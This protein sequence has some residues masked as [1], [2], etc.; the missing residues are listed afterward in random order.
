MTTYL[1]QVLG[2]P[3]WDAKGN[4]LGQCVDVLVAEAETGFPSMRALA[5]R[6]GKEPKLISAEC[7]AWL[8]PSI[9]LGTC[10]PPL[11]QVKGDELWLARQ[12]LDRQI[13]DTEGRRLVRVNDLQLA[14]VAT[15]GIR[16]HLAAVDVGTL[17]LLRRLGVENVAMRLFNILRRKP[18]EIVIPWN[19]VAPLQADE[20]IH[21]RISRDKIGELHPADIADIIEELDRPMGQALLQTL[22]NETIADTM[23]EI[24]PELQA[25]MLD[26]LPSERAADVLEEMDPDEAADIL[27]DLGPERRAELLDLMEDEDATDVEKLLKYP[28]N[29]AGGVMT[30]EFATVPAGLRVS[31]AL[32]Y[33]R[34]S[35]DAL[36]DEALYYVYIVDADQKL[37]GVVALRD[38]VLAAPDRPVQEIMDTDIITVDPL[39][40]QT[41]VA[42]LAAKYNLLAVPVVDSSNVMHGIVTADDAIDVI[43]PTKWKKR[44]PRFF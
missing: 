3:V 1:S 29:T 30:T 21:L 43:I 32:D 24:Q 41:D 28:E 6:N 4:R 7:I 35:R 10:E 27:G 14:R 36:K 2:K 38:L 15:N 18:V 31:E 25:S 33:L 20:P 39:Q 42:R 26:T 9:I 17:G 37:Q 12:V 16:Y 19:E 5:L 34:Q 23:Q 44:L 13:V 11:Y 8:S 40:A 22:D